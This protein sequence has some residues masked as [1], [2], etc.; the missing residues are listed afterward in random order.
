MEKEL[1]EQIAK[2]LSKHNRDSFTEQAEAIQPI[3]DS[4]VQTERERVVSRLLTMVLSIDQ[5]DY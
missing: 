2:V 3:I 4:Q 5:I 1:R